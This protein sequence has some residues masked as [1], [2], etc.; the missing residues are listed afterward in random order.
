MTKINAKMLNK[1]PKT[2]QMKPDRPLEE[3]TI[4]QTTAQANQMKIISMECSVNEKG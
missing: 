1:A 2:N 3:A 4:A